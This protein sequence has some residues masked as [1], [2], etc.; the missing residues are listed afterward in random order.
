[1]S[2]VSFTLAE[3]KL[4]EKEHASLELQS[5]N[6]KTHQVKKEKIQRMQ[7]D[8]SSILKQDVALKENIHT[9]GVILLVFRLLYK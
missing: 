1:M 8:L 3:V 2:D 7:K 5:L 6:T 4:T 9:Y